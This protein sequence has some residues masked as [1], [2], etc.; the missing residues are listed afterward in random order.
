[1]FMKGENTLDALGLLKIVLG[2]LRDF[3]SKRVSKLSHH[4]SEGKKEHLCGLNHDSIILRTST[5]ESNTL[6]NTA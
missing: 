1:M 2:F 3:D 5:D 6:S 4:T